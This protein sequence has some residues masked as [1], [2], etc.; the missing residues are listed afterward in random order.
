VLVNRNKTTE[1][2]ARSEERRN[3]SRV[4][5]STPVHLRS[6]EDTEGSL[7]DTTTTVNLSAD[8]ILINT[9][10]DAYYRS[11]KIRV[12]LPYVKSAGA[13]QAEQAGHV[14]RIV[15]LHGGLRS[16]AIALGSGFGNEVVHRKE[17]K[18]TQQSIRPLVLVVE[19]ES[20][21]SEFMK[22][23]LSGEGYEVITVGTFA[24]AHGVLDLR[25]PSLLIAEIEGADKPGYALCSHCKET[26]RLKSMPVMLMTS[27]AYPSDYAKAHSVGAVVCMAKPYKR[28]RLGH[29]V[30]L[31]AP[32]PNSNNKTAPPRRADASRHAGGKRLKASSGVTARR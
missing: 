16:V 23:Y 31:L 25:T 26:P 32:P 22:T 17:E 28:E 1:T 8:G 29:V 7:D 2:T 14:V 20:V 11:M 15:E 24:E 3:R 6:L 13:T 21:A 4:L 19:S 12:T 30:K 27:S 9:A 18:S 5:V 10:N